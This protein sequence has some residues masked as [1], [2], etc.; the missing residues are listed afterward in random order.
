MNS[1]RALASFRS[2]AQESGTTIS[3]S[4]YDGGY[5][6]LLLALHVT[7]ASLLSITCLTI[8]HF[9]SMSSLRSP[10]RRITLSPLD[11]L[12]A[13]SLEHGNTPAAARGLAPISPSSDICNRKTSRRRRRR[14]R[15][16]RN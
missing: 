10:A 9:P 2:N 14:R 12:E 16:R 3:V 6:P 1:E 4:V 8:P 11:T 5:K 7:T 13:S 15:R